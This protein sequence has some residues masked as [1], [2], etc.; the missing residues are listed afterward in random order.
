ME[1]VDGL[2]RLDAI[3]AFIENR[4]PYFSD[5]ESEGKYFNLETL[6]LTKLLRDEGKLTQRTPEMTREESLKVTQYTLPIS[7]YEVSESSD[8]DE[9]FRRINSSGRKLGTQEVR[10]AGSINKI[11]GLVRTIS[12]EIRGDATTSE[13]LP[14]ASMRQYSLIWKN[15]DSDE[16]I[17]VDD[18]FWVRH[19]IIHRDDLRSSKDEQLVLDLLIDILTQGQ[20]ETSGKTR[21]DAYDEDSDL[22]QKL[23]RAIGDK[24]SQEII[25]KQ[26]LEIKDYIEKI[27]HENSTEQSWRAHTGKPS[28]NPT[29]RY[30]HVAFM[31]LYKLRFERG[32]I[33]N[34]WEKISEAT[35]GYWKGTKLK[36]GGTWRVTPRIKEINKFIGAIQDGFIKSSDPIVAKPRQQLDRFKRE[37]AKYGAVEKQFYEI[38]MGLSDLSLNEDSDKIQNRRAFF[39]NII[40]TA[41]AMANTMPGAEGAIYIGIADKESTGRKIQDKFGVEPLDFSEINKELP[42]FIFGIDHELKYFNLDLDELKRTLTSWIM[43]CGKVDNEDFLRTLANSIDYIR[44][45]DGGSGV[46]TILALYPRSVDDLVWY[47]DACY[48]RIGSSN[49]KLTG[50]SFM[51]RLKYF[52]FHSS[53]KE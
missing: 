10:Q 41:T 50:E 19:G 45:S 29:A 49:E 46:R 28:N 26:F 15:D 6:G 5:N 2:Q 32:Q 22:T 34:N 44:L 24:N 7:T 3:I 13:I 39:E 53:G 33:P 36:T 18:T 9:T 30:F 12:S 20:H 8:I 1:I 42:R 14:L 52:E 11:A 40:K 27:V 43:R 16:G 38:K 35:K 51:D 37:F 48:E 31:A 47:G 23:N 21:D 4:F 17:L 25:C